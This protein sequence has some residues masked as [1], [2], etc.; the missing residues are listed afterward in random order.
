MQLRNG[1]AFAGSNRED[2]IVELPTFE[3][4]SE[5]HGT[6]SNLRQVCRCDVV[7]HFGH[8][9]NAECVA[10]VTTDLTTHAGRQTTCFAVT[11][12]YAT[13]SGISLRFP[14]ELV[15]FMHQG[16]AKDARRCSSRQLTN[17]PSQGNLT[18]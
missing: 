18:H 2:L 11:T 15:V 4:I 5:T 10:N 9:L 8:V 16:A 3:N 14:V 17:G 1:A 13:S 7:L 12:A 6:A